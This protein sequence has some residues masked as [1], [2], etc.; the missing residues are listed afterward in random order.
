MNRKYNGISVQGMS[1][2]R[3]AIS[4]GTYI[5]LAFDEMAPKKLFPKLAY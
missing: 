5:K 4:L 2:L 3:N 1:E